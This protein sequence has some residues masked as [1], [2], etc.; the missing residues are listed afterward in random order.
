MP[1]DSQLKIKNELEMERQSK[2]AMKEGSD[3][4]VEVFVKI[5]RRKSK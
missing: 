5:L 3:R 1:V 2:L 4:K